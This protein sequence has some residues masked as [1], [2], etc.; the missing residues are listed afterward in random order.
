MSQ[1]NWL[2]GEIV[3]TGTEILLGQI[4]D[5]NAAWIA[6]QLNAIGIHL[7]Y[8]STVGDNERRLCELLRVC[9][10]RSD[11]VIVTGGLGPTADD[12]TR[13][14][15]ARATG[16]SLVLHQPTLAN[17]RRRFSNWG[18][19]MTA[20]NQ[21]QALMPSGADIVPNP[22]GTAPG[23]CVEKDGCLLF[24]LPGVPREMKRLM[25]ETVLPR[26]QARAGGAGVIRVRTLRTIG[27]GESALDQE[28]RDLMEASNPTVGLAAHTGQADVRLTARGEHEAEAERL[29]DAV[30]KDV[31]AR[32]GDFVYS[33]QK[34][35]GI[36][37][38]IVDL[39]AARK[40]RLVVI[41]QDRAAPIAARLRRAGGDAIGDDGLQAR[42]EI[43]TRPLFPPVDAAESAYE[44]AVPRIAA[45]LAAA[46][47]AA[48]ALAVLGTTDPE[49]GVYQKERGFTWILCHGPVGARQVRLNFGGA[50]EITM[51]WKGN[52]CFDLLRRALLG[53]D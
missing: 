36:A 18:A 3:T 7:Y 53:L 32:V 6:Q 35:K 51:V 42:I 5:T 9:M 2:K 43:Q 49:H 4:V 52:R 14:A 46:G 27:T 29:L 28:L 34:D 31:R 10:Q 41:E 21:Q 8:K 23:F 11:V 20:N 17:I 26:L 1:R 45:A 39:W 40:Q 15:I 44:D 12:I 16:A 19:Q 48:Y 22:V 33:T 30:E 38:H 47:S 24:A 37:E 50:D 13:Q 25:Q